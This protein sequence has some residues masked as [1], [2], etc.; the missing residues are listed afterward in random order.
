MIEI[1]ARETLDKFIKLSLSQNKNNILDIGCGI[2]LPHTSIMR[3]SDLN[4][5][6]NDFFNN[7]YIGKFVDINIDRKFDGIWCCHVLEHQQNVNTFL[8]K[9]Y[10]TLEDDGLLAITV[11][12]L[13]HSIVGG[14]LTLWNMG[15]LYYNLVSAGFDCSNAIHRKYGYNISIILNKKSIVNMPNLHYDKGDIELL[16]PYFPFSV[17]QG[18]DG[19]NI[20]NLF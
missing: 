16:A 4:V 8:T 9:I 12:P 15:L 20:P 18:F 19:D 7:D 6:T 10:D 3:N 1:R 5:L 11:P 13:K 17:C 2:H 14:H